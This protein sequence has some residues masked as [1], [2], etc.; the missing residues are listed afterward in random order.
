MRS[1][2]CDQSSLHVRVP[3]SRFVARIK[4]VW[5]ESGE[6]NA[7]AVFESFPSLIE[8]HSLAK[9]LVFDEYRAGKKRA[10]TSILPSFVDVILVLLARLPS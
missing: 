10:K 2:L 6:P 3:A 1:S 4:S 9:E 5:R 7:Q 8:N